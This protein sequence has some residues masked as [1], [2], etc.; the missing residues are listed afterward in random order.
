METIILATANPNKAIE[1]K[2]LL[3][4]DV[5]V[6]TMKDLGIDIDIIEDGQTFEENALIKVR[7]LKP[8]IEQEAIIIGDDSGLSVDALAGQPGVYS[9]RYAGENV[10]YKD[11]N[12]KLLKEMETIPDPKRG[13]TF[14]TVMAILYPDGQ[15]II[16]KGMVRG[17]IAR[18]FIGHGGFGYDPLFIHEE[19]GR[20]Y[21]EMTED[22]KNKI[23]H[24]ALAI[25]K[26]KDHLL[27]K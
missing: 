25:K 24:R 13:A 1:I 12:I 11:N 22:E 21:G 7:T 20:S 2:N 3:K 4:N 15:E 5:E 10:T 17:K 26:V 8:F 19:S 9:A 18:D 27:K 6:L 23:S 14:I 16:C